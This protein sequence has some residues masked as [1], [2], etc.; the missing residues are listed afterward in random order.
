MI[1]PNALKGCR[2]AY[3]GWFRALENRAFAQVSAM[4]KRL[5]SDLRTLAGNYRQEYFSMLTSVSQRGAL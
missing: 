5:C 1:P 4:H 2:W 3:G